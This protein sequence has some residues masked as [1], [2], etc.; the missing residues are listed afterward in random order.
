MGILRGPQRVWGV[1]S[2]PSV[3]LVPP[4]PQNHCAVRSGSLPAGLLAHTPVEGLVISHGG[5]GYLGKQPG[6]CADQFT[7]EARLVFRA[8][9]TV[10]LASGTS[11]SSLRQL[12]GSAR[13]SALDI[14]PTWH[15]TRPACG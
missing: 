4:F 2:P 12:L 13:L 14:L 8:G 7:P 1:Q 10:E 11:S 15:D 9:D 5:G 3:S 6:I